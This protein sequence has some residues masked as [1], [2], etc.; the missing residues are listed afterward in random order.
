MTQTL[1]RTQRKP[2]TLTVEQAL[3]TGDLS[4]LDP[5]ARL[6]YYMRVC[7]SLGLNPLTKPFDYL[8]LYDSRTKGTKLVL[9]A[10]KDATDQL[11]NIHK[12]SITRLE[13]EQIGDLLVVTATAALPDG[14]S[15]SE[16]GAVNI[17]GLQGDALANAMMR[18]STK[19]KRRVTLSLCGLGMTDE[20]EV[21][22]IPGAYYP[23]ET[24]DD[25]PLPTREQEVDDRDLVRSADERIWKRWLQL[26]D[27]A[28]GLG[29]N[30]VTLRLPVE[31][32]ELKQ[33]GNQLVQD[34]SDRQEQ[35]DKEEAARIVSQAEA[36]AATRDEDLD[37][38]E[39]ARQ[40]RAG[41]L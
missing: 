14:R 16:I 1:A 10:R 20:S 2:E 22:S 11:R 5:D 38:I 15:D 28:Q 4:G 21:D 34:I 25:V 3:V 6:N 37:R 24:R 27:E 29:L 30:P 9:Y 40:K 23:E 18:A 17:A 36:A 33:R 13:R 12:V 26:L 31:R 8:S 19:A 35:L 32:D 7:E 41:E 39:V